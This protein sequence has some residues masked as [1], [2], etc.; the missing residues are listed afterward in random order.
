MDPN[1]VMGALKT[2][3]DDIEGK[4]ATA[5]TVEEKGRLNGVLDASEA[6]AQKSM[7]ESKRTD[8]LES[9]ITELTEGI[10]KSRTDGETK[11]AEY[12][13]QLDELTGAL[14]MKTAVT[15]DGADYKE[16]GEYKALTQWLVRPDLISAE[17][18]AELRTDTDNAAGF[19]VPGALDSILLKEIVELDSLRSLART[20][21]IGVK[22]LDMPIRDGIPSATYE[23]EAGS[24]DESLSNYRMVS[25]TPYRQT[26]TV[27]VTMDMLMNGGFDIESEIRGDVAESF[28]QGEGNGFVVGTGVKQPEGF[29]QNALYIAGVTAQ[30]DMSGIATTDDALFSDAIVAMPGEL[31]TGYNGTYGF[32]RRTIARIRQLRDTNGA[33]LWM[34]SI[35]M[36]GAN[37]NTIN[38]HP[39]IE[40]P[41]LS[42]W[43]TAGAG[44]DV[45]VF[46][47]FNRGYSIIDRVGVSVVRDEVT[48]AAQAI[49]KLTFHRWNTGI[50]TIAEA[51]KGMQDA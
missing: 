34:P 30:T 20:R 48:A 39:Y 31:K 25:V 3:R 19:L 23:G 18:K 14:A 8:N 38:G 47:D 4:L 15:G 29:T 17:E 51:F 43:D 6:Q 24:G 26:V 2:L 33:F 7:L 21:T 45:A 27:P 35:G 42:D 41:S 13:A 44:N 16:S 28:A 36:A 11:S 37:P 5:L 50:V 1:E 9:Q 12:Q 40:L 10:E 22:T 49:I 46:A 32:S